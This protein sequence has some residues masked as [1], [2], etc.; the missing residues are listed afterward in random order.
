LIEAQT[1]EAR[2]LAE[3]HSW[4]AELSLHCGI[5]ATADFTPG[6]NSVAPPEGKP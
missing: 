1:T 4:L 5:D 3:H 6:A 2:A